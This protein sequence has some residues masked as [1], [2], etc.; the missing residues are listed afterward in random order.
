MEPK[1]FF[2]KSTCDSD[3]HLEMRITGLSQGEGQ[4]GATNKKNKK[5]EISPKKE[6][7]IN[8]EVELDM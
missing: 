7:I 8:S 1:Y 5:N 6:K 3:E 2:F 4:K